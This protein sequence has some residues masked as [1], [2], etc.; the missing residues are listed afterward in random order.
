MLEPVIV[1]FFQKCKKKTSGGLILSLENFGLIPTFRKTYLCSKKH[2]FRNNWSHIL[3]FYYINVFCKE[4]K[5][6]IKDRIRPPLVIVFAFLNKDYNERIM[7]FFKYKWTELS[8][9]WAHFW[10][11]DLCSCSNSGLSLKFSCRIPCP[12]HKISS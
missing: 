1:I 7:S 3:T 5:Y 11:N 9:L 10:T 2:K 12:C 8:R 4:L 6:G